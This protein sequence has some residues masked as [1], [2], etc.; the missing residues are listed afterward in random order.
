MSHPTARERPAERIFLVFVNT[1]VSEDE[2]VEAE[3]E[4][5]CVA[6]G[7]E[8]VGSLRQRVNKPHRPTFIGKGKVEELTS[9]AEEVEADTVVIDTELSGTQIKNLEEAV[10]KRVIDRTQLI[11][12]IF[13]RRARTKEGQLQVELA[14][15]RYRLPRL[16][17]AWTKFER[18]RGGIGMRGPGETQLE[19]D[20]RTVNKRISKLSAEIDGLFRQRALQR[21]SRK[22]KPHSVVAIVGYTSAGKSTLMNRLVGAD[23]LVD[24]MPFATLDPTTRKLELDKGFSCFLVDTVGFIRRLPTQ[25]VAA[26]RGTLEEVVHADLLVH[27]VDASQ[28]DWEL[29]RD[30]VLDTVRELGAEDVPM[31]TVFNKI[32]LLSDSSV[33]TRLV[34]EWP[35]S[36]AISAAI[37]TGIPDLLDLIVAKCESK[38]ELVKALIPYDQTRLVESCH[39][40]GR[41]LVKDYREDGVYLE[42]ELV[43]EMRSKLEKYEVP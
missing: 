32:D 8:V 33:A 15:L 9:Y 25:L 18:Q 11:L 13:A 17:S 34:A 29:Q 6:V 3:L 26:F 39:Q 7:A 37:G 19:R 16:M 4:G 27:V 30:S 21:D 5:L 24:A 36:V 40:Y 14:Q 1:D 2:Y 20:R 35:D 31:I 41:V 12:D 22:A 42:A 28:E 23:V 43:P 10:G 38:L